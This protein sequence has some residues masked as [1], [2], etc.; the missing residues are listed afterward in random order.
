MDIN[1]SIIEFTRRVSESLMP[2]RKALR[3]IRFVHHVDFIR[4]DIVKRGFFTGTVD[5]DNIF[6]TCIND[7]GNLFSSY[8]E[9]FKDWEYSVERT[10][11]KY[12]LILIAKSIKPQDPT[13]RIMGIHGK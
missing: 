11:H 5:T 13:E 10:D 6:L 7:V 2:A 4:L 8:V 12:S 9:A 3:K 1:P